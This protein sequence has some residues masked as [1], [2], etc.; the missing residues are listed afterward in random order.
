VP[1]LGS[2]FSE[3]HA[4]LPF[5][6]FHMA[7]FKRAFRDWY[8]VFPAYVLPHLFFVFF[9]QSGTQLFS[10]SRTGPSVEEVIFFGVCFSAQGLTEPFSL[11][12]RFF[13]VVLLLIPEVILWLYTL[14][15]FPPTIS[16]SICGSPPAISRAA[17][18][19]EER[20]TIH[21]L[22]LPPVRFPISFH[23]DRETRPSHFR[24]ATPFPRSLG[25]GNVRGC[26]SWSPGL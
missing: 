6:L 7:T 9:F 25:R 1:S 5:F 21:K 22:F 13:A 11:P 20:F 17:P 23:V 4:K 18:P 15:I 14:A 3:H 24:L 16:L 26:T 12:P 8:H 10:S 19:S 2:P